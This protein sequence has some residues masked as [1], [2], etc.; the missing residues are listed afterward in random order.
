MD[1]L[2]IKNCSSCTKPFNCGDDFQGNSCW[3]ADFPPVFSPLDGVDCLCPSCFAT[4]CSIKIEEYVGTITPETAKGNKAATL[5]K[6]DQLIEGIDYYI[7]QGNYV[8]KAWF[9]LKRGH[10]CT[11]GCRHCPYGF[12]K[13]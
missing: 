2:K 4:A 11:N 13:K 1:S 5:P 3:C 12:K 9:H 8:F 10:C 6:T 7:A